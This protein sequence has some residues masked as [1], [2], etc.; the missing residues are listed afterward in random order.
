LD[1]SGANAWGVSLVVGVGTTSP[2]CPQHQAANLAG[3]SKLLYGAVVNGPNGADNF[4][5]LPFLHG[6]ARIFT[7]IC[8][9]EPPHPT[10]AGF[11]PGPPKELVG[12]S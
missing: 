1:R 3:P 12:K 4:A 5:D 6:A 10:P 11:A 2:R 9:G 7:V 8:G